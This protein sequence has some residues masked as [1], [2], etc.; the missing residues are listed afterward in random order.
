M[1]DVLATLIND[2]KLDL[3]QLTTFNLD[4]CVGLDEDDDQSYHYFIDKHLFSKL[5][6]P[7]ENINIL[8][9]VASDLDK[10]VKE[11]V[12]L[13]DKVGIDMQVLG[14]IGRASS[15]ERV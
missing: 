2:E 8:D 10:E 13:I 3:S 11:Y 14:K 9:G 6:I 12:S 5:D 1:Y 15:R 4:E 7:K